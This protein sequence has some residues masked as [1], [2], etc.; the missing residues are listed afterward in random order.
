MHTKFLHQAPSFAK[1]SRPKRQRLLKILFDDNMKW[2]LNESSRI[3]NE[4]RNS[5]KTINI[6]HKLKILLSEKKLSIGK[7]NGERNCSR[8]KSN[9][10]ICL[11]LEKSFPRVSDNLLHSY[12][13]TCVNTM[14]IQPSSYK[15]VNMLTQRKIS[16]TDFWDF[17][18]I[19]IKLVKNVF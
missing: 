14:Q 16:L 7:S 9:A 3:W 5:H 2:Q 11:F 10:N 6:W 18:L 13:H 19:C 12:I 15:C 8:W 1:L 17:W 4:K